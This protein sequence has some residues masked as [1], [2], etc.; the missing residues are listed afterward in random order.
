[1]LF[2]AA[3]LC[4]GSVN[5]Q[6]ELS[7]DEMKT[8]SSVESVCGKRKK[9]RAKRS[10]TCCNYENSSS[11]S[12]RGAEF[13]SRLTLAVLQTRL[14]SAMSGVIY[15]SSFHFLRHW[16]YRCACDLPTG[17]NATETEMIGPGVD[18]TFTARADDIA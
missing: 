11:P 10:G 9:S 3:A 12:W 6:K 15:W 1:M 17:F 7:A 18:L 16:S 5:C 4:T 8:L 14:P 13:R 2:L